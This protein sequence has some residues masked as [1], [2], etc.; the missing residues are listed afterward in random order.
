MVYGGDVVGLRANGNLRIVELGDGTTLVT[1]AVVIASGVSY[2][3][4]EIPSLAA[5]QGTGVY[6]GSALSEARALTG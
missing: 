3:T 5:L 6:Y 2:C 1:R 4:L